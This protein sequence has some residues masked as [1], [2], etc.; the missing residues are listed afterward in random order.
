MKYA[1]TLLCSTILLASCASQQNRQV[2]STKPQADRLAAP[3]YQLPSQQLNSDKQPMLTIN[4]YSRA[5]VHELMSN[6]RAAEETGMVG[7]TDFSYVDS[8]LD[9]G[10]VLSNHLS[11]AIMYDLHKFGVAVLDYK[12]TDYIRVTPSGDFALSRDFNELSAELPIR[13]VVTGTM[14]AHKS[15]VLLNARLIR[16]DTKQVISAARTFVPESVVNAVISNTG[17]DKLQLKQG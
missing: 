12:V 2:V 11:E 17:N 8:S 10:S 4:E 16:I 14:T 5:L 7:V 3:A 9:K 13:F 1:L 6:H 15:G